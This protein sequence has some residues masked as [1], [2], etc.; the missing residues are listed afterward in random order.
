MDEL[1]RLEATLRALPASLLREAV[2]A[3]CSGQ[4]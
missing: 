2:D 1:E 3:A 4:E